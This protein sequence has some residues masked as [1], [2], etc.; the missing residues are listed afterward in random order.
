MAEPG[1][2]ERTS[3]SETGIQLL[4]YGTCRNI[5]G[6]R[7]DEF[8]NLIPWVRRLPKSIEKIMNSACQQR[9]HKVKNLVT[10]TFLVLALASILIPKVTAEEPLDVSILQLIATPKTFDGK[11]VRVVGFLHLEF[12]GNELYLHKV[13]YDNSIYFNGIWVDLNRDEMKAKMS[14]DL[15][16]VLVTGIFDATKRGHNGLSSGTISKIQNIEIWSEKKSTK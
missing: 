15:K 10:L 7:L 11:T 12:E 6:L 3:P 14:L 4:D 16:Y 1:A 8:L 5:W 9:S 13:D 2:K